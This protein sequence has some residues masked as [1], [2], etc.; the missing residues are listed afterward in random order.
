MR[1]GL[2]RFEPLVMFP[3]LKNS[4]VGGSTLAVEL[5]AKYLDSNNYMFDWVTTIVNS[6]FS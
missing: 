6:P 5:L 2:Q 3:D 1:L 4:C